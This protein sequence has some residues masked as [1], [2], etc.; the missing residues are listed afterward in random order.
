MFMKAEK[1]ICRFDTMFI[2]DWNFKL[3]DVIDMK[4]KVNEKSAF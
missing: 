2:T 1:C 3:L 4:I